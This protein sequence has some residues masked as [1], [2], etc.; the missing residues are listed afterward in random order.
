MPLP[1]PPPPHFLTPLQL[2]AV[3]NHLH[4][5]VLQHIDLYRAAWSRGSGSAEVGVVVANIYRPPIPSDWV[6]PLEAAVEEEGLKLDDAQPEGGERNEAGGGGGEDV[7][8]S[9]SP[10]VAGLTAEERSRVMTVKAELERQLRQ[11]RAEAK[12]TAAP[13]T[14]AAAVAAL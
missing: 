5:R 4:D 6:M 2:S 8:L 7:E 9:L 11:A 1:P 14:A 10:A 13:A 3:F 12:A